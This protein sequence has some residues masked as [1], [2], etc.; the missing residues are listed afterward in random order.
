MYARVNTF[1]GP[2]DRIDEAVRNVREQ[3]LP[4]LQRQDGFKGLIGLVE[5]RK[6][7]DK[8]IPKNILELALLYELSESYIAGMPLSLQKGI[9]GALA[10]VAR[11]GLRPRVIPVHQ[12]RRRGGGAD[13]SFGDEPKNRGGANGD[14]WSLVVGLATQP[15]KQDELASAPHFQVHAL[16]GSGWIGQRG[17]A[18]AVRPRPIGRRC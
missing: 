7:N 9:F 8:A 13:A 2:P 15:P 1:E 12:A 3:I 14:A 5:D 18:G 11:C 16:P 6:T 17:R 4:Q 10:R